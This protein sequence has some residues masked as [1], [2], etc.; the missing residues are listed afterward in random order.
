MEGQGR[1]HVNAFLNHLSIANGS[2]R[3]TETQLLVATRL[4]Y[5]TDEELKPLLELS[6]EVGRL[7]TGLRRSLRDN[8]N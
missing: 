4:N 1:G 5:I 8:A 6:D 2:L 3:E 7:L